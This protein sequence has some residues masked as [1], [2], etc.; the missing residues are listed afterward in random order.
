MQ[1]RSRQG[2]IPNCPIPRR[3]LFRHTRP[4]E[5]SKYC[6]R[7]RHFHARRS[8]PCMGVPKKGVGLSRS[9]SCRER[10]CCRVRKSSR[11]RNISNY[12]MPHS[13]ASVI[14]QEEPVKDWKQHMANDFALNR[15]LGLVG[16]RSDGC[17]TVL[18]CTPHQRRHCQNAGG[19]D[20]LPKGRKGVHF[21]DL[22]MW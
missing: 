4:A 6:G 8:C 15:P 17:G 21:V 11:T 10:P 2:L 12:C 14:S 7:V 22:S 20:S 13:A 3:S 16:R 19:R 9:F 1:A 5:E 18:M